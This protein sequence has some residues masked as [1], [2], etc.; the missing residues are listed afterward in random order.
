MFRGLSQALYSCAAVFHNP[1]ASH[2]IKH[3]VGAGRCPEGR[4]RPLSPAER[5]KE[6]SKT[7]APTPTSSP[8]PATGAKRTHKKRWGAKRAGR[9]PGLHAKGR[10]CRTTLELLQR[11]LQLLAEQQNPNVLE[12]VVTVLH[13]LQYALPAGRSRTL[14]DRGELR[15][16]SVLRGLRARLGCPS[17]G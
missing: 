8:T 5:E 13:L 9:P 3:R 11:L 12:E 14:R 4:T 16:L 15:S 1:K 7:T 17:T 2:S 10:E 6:E